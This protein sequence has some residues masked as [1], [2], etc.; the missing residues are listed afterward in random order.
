MAAIGWLRVALYDMR[1]VAF[2]H[3]ETP[4]RH[5]RSNIDYSSEVLTRQP[6]FLAGYWGVD[7]DD[8][9]IAA[10][11]QWAGW[12]AIEAAQGDLD[13]LA[14]DAEVHGVCRV[15]LLNLELFPVSGAGPSAETAQT[16]M[17]IVSYAIDARNERAQTYMAD[18]LQEA[19]AE[20]QRQPGFQSG[21]WGRDRGA[22]TMAVLTYWDSRRAIAAARPVLQQLQAH[23]AA[24]GFRVVDVHNLHL[25]ATT[26]PPAGA[27]AEGQGVAGFLDAL[28][29]RRLGA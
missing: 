18:H 26:P 14:A 5:M 27:G 28:Q 25:F 29:Q 7:L 9:K 6:G 17:R 12:S 11:T 1:D 23:A 16:R 2:D 15:H 10:V 8:A 4:L 24:A 20:L 3:F 13:R 21:C 19:R 22:A